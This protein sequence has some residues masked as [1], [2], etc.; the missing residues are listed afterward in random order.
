MKFFQN[1][2]L[3]FSLLIA[4]L[5]YA[6]DEISLNGDW[7]I[8]FDHKNEGAKSMWHQNEVFQNG[9]PEWLLSFRHPQPEKFIK[10]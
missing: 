10:S 4:Q 3:P 7:E 5:N 6:Q 8:V 1:I 9:L 2:L